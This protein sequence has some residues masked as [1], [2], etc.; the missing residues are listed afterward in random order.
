MGRACRAGIVPEARRPA[1]GSRDPV[2]RHPTALVRAVEPAA[3]Q[4]GPAQGRLRR[5]PTG[6]PG[7]D[8][9][10]VTAFERL[11]IFAARHRWWVVAAWAVVVLIAIPL[12]PRRLRRPPRRWVLAR[13]PA[14]RP[15][16]RLARRR[17]RRR[18]VGA[19]HR[20]R[21]ADAPGRHGRVR[22]RRLPRVGRRRLGAARRRGHVAPVRPEPGLGRRAHRLRR[23]PARP[24]AGRLP[25]GAP[26][27][28]GRARPAARDDRRPRRRPGVLRRHPDRLRVRPPPQ[29]AHQPAARRPRAPPRLRVRSSRPA[30]R[31]SSAGQPSSSS[32]AI[33][34][35]LASV[36][37]MS[38]FVLNLATLLGLGPRRGL[39]APHDQPVPGGA[40]AADRRRREADAGRHRGRHP[41]DGRHRRA[42]GLLL[43]P[44]RPPR[45]PRPRP[46][47]VHGPPVGRDR[48]RARRRGR[49]RLGA[50][51]PPGDPRDPRDAARLAPGPPRPRDGG[52]GRGLGPPRAAGHGPADPRARPDARRAAPARRAV[53]PRPVQRPDAS[54]L[55]ATVPSR[56][57]F[58]RL[59]QQ[60]SEGDFAPISLSVRTTGPATDAAERRRALR[61]DP[62]RLAADPRVSQVV[63]IVDLDPRITLDQYRLLYGTRP[64]RGTGSSRRPSTATTKGDLTA[65]TL[66]TPYGPNRD[67]AKS[68]VRDLRDPTG[69]LAPPAGMT[70][71]VVAA[72]RPTSA[73]SSAGSAPTSRGPPCSS[74]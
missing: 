26:R 12:A 63:S 13:R 72:G 40:R 64:G 37:P 39:L 47:R 21:L 27:H 17:A 23:R 55:P 41:G 36:M 24:P 7:H 1:T 30:S 10:S 52:I 68:L 42:G 65:I 33:V 45:P 6:L 71:G 73:T 61:L 50:H 31:S 51:A 25:E 29:R 3:P 16:A 60:F 67:E 5:H 62:R 43:R 9:E 44:H 20:L 14:V 49:G 15:G 69:P 19:R 66:F 54:I 74:S 4:A 56:V 2:R 58:D 22:A 18:A 59:Q 57:A 28:R 35:L 53:P 8:Q 38:V 32:L 70:V 11:G 34:F 46:V 48:R